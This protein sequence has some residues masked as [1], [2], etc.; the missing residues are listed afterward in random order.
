MQITEHVVHERL[1]AFDGLNDV[2]VGGQTH[3]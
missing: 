1:L 2:L 3:L